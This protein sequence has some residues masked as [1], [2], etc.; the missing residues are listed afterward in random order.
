MR[1]PIRKHEHA[2]RVYSWA[3]LSASSK[4][5]NRAHVRNRILSRDPPYLNRSWVSYEILRIQFYKS[6]GWVLAIATTGRLS[7]GHVAHIP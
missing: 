5:H 4:T 3:S 7:P 6:D 2:V 1:K